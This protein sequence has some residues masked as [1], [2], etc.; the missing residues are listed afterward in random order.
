MRVCDICHNAGIMSRT[1][2]Q[3]GQQGTE[4]ELCPQCEQ[5]V[6]NDA[7]R[8]IAFHIAAHRNGDLITRLK[9]T[10]DTKSRHA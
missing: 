8:A 2:V 1:T 9:V 3:P 10:A 6:L 5:D 7:L 4:V